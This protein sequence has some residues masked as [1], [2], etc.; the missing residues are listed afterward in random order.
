MSRR[1]VRS[2]ISSRST[3]SRPVHH[4]RDDSSVRSRRSRAGVSTLHHLR[5]CGRVLSATGRTL[6]PCIPISS[7]T[8]PSTTRPGC[9]PKPSSAGPAVRCPAG[10]AA[11]AGGGGVSRPRR[12]VRQH[13]AMSTS[14]Q[15]DGTVAVKAPLIGTV[16]SLLVAEG[17]TVRAGQAVV[18]LES[19]KMEH[20]VEADV[21]GV[22]AAFTMVPADTVEIDQPLLWVTEGE[23]DH[24]ADEAADELDLGHVRPD[25]AEVVARHAKTKDP[26]RPEAIAKHHAVGHR[27]TREN[28]EDL[29][30]P[31]SFVEY[32]SLMV[33]AQRRRRS[34]EDLIDRTPGDGMVAGTGHVNG[35]RFTPERSRCVVV[36]YDYTVLAG[37]QGHYNHLKK[38]RMFELAE[39][40][41]L[42]VVL[43]A[44]GG[45]GRPGDTDVPGVAGLDVM[46]FYLFSRLSGLVHLVGIVAG[47]CF[48]GN[49][50][51]VGCCDV[52]IATHDT[53]LGVGGPAMIEGG[54]LGV[55]RPE[56]VG[57]MDVQVPNGVVDIAVADETEA[58][59]VAKRY[60]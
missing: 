23:V 36:S 33:A 56:E 5:S 30:D 31:G 53:N 54:G 32:G 52:I 26:A 6:T 38:D 45:G 49:A 46:A 25:L 37:T 11:V 8:S 14:P 22:V 39:R 21:T 19:M 42:P 43:F 59:A 44:E 50:V 12:H 18:I 9:W 57:P 2:V 10:R 60:L 34:V 58:V 16:V 1:R 24:V 3:S 7:A 51:L 20:L 48:A 47:R 40:N 41:R 35:D 15:L 4:G 17:D 27:S 29:C 55:F 13:G 28:V